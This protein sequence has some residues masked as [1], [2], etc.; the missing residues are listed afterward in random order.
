MRDPIADEPCTCAALSITLDLAP[1]DLLILVSRVACKVGKRAQATLFERLI[2]VGTRPQ[3]AQD[4]L[5]AVD[6]QPK[7]TRPEDRSARL[8]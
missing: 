7:R 5:R 2:E 6:A 1:M 8:R 4:L 3:L